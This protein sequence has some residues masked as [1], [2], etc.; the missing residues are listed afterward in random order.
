MIK[1]FIIRIKNSLDVGEVLNPSRLFPN[2][3]PQMNFYFERVP[4][5]SPTLVARWDIGKT[6]SCLDG[7]DFIDFHKLSYADDLVSLQA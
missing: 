3:T 1:L 6:V 7:E 5:K 4:V 2:F